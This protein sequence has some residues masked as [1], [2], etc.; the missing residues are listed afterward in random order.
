MKTFLLLISFIFACSISH[1]DDTKKEAVDL[2]AHKT[3]A[4]F[5]KAIEVYNQKKDESDPAIKRIGKQNYNLVANDTTIRFSLVNYLN[6]Q[7]YVNDQLV[8]RSSFGLNTKTVST[9]IFM[10]AFSSFNTTLEEIGMMCFSGCKETSREVNLKKIINT[11]EDQRISCNEHLYA[12]ED[13]IKKY[14]SFRMVS[15]LHSAFN[16]EFQSVRNFYLKVAETNKKSVESFMSKK[17]AFTKDYENCIGVM[18]AGTMADENLESIKA[19]ESA[20]NICVKMDELKSCLVNLKKNLS[21][22]NSIKRS[23]KKASSID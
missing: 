4:D 6:N 16:P 20:R 22:A 5:Q 21:A 18:S 12:K 17:K 19:L 1:G 9:K 11:L 14:P 15:L 13:T 23:S 2:L 7:M 3:I 8:E 10:H